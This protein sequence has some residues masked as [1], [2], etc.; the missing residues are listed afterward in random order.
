MTQ[1]VHRHTKIVAS[2][3]FLLFLSAG[4]ALADGINSKN[5]ARISM[6]TLTAEQAQ[7]KNY[8]KQIYLSNAVSEEKKIAMAVRRIQRGLLRKNNKE[9][10]TEVQTP[11]AVLG[12]DRARMIKRHLQRIPANCI[13]LHTHER[14]ACQKNAQLMKTHFHVALKAER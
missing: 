1:T 11:G 14:A 10:T 9:V 13:R 6:P 3:A 4:A 7:V 8:K 2:C 5:K 12:I